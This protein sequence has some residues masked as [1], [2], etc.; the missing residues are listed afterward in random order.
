MSNVIYFFN[1]DDLIRI[2]QSQLEC[3]E[4]KANDIAL[5]LE[6]KVSIFF[7]KMDQ[8]ISNSIVEIIEEY[9]HED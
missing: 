5:D 4:D 9:Q 6:S 1:F 2:I 8:N 7:D 3:D